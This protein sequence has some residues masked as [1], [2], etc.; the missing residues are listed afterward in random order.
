MPG[1][2]Q[3]DEKPHGELS[4]GMRVA[5]S[6]CGSNIKIKIKDFWKFEMDPS[7]QTI[8]QAV[9]EKSLHLFRFIIHRNTSLFK[10]VS[11]SI[12]TLFIYYSDSVHLNLAGRISRY[13]LPRLTGKKKSPLRSKSTEEE[14]WKEWLCL[15]LKTTRVQT[16]LKTTIVVQYIH[17][18]ATVSMTHTHTQ[19]RMHA[20]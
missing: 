19:T 20:A 9:N 11:V 7:I 1:F 4:E 12:N 6:R 3:G 2:C 18:L 16:G 13:G 10:P 15:Q 14:E 8:S 17:N 5:R